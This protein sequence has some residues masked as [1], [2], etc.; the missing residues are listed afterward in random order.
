[1]NKN[2]LLSRISAFG[3]LLLLV[4]P[5]A[6]VWLK[7]KSPVFVLHD[8]LGKIRFIWLVSVM[9]IMISIIVFNVL[10]ENKKRNIAIITLSIIYTAIYI[11]PFMFF[12]LAKN[13]QILFPIASIT[14]DIS[15]YHN[16]D[17]L[18]SAEANVILENIFPQK[19]PSC[20]KNVKYEYFYNP[21]DFS[22]KVKLTFSADQATLETLK[23]QIKKDDWSIYSNDTCEAYYYDADGIEYMHISFTH[24]TVEYLYLFLMASNDATFSNLLYDPNGDIST[25]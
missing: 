5:F 23:K 6:F 10:K 14:N 21:S 13:V 17:T 4:I 18:N 24:E 22:T 19:I 3:M 12:A 25:N 9:T 8:F 11:V 7:L 15:E 20:A 1:M 16:F 2:V